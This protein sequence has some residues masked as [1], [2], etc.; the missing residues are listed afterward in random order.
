[1]EDVFC[2]VKSID[3]RKR[4]GVAQSDQLPVCRQHFPNRRNGR[5]ARD[6]GGIRD[7]FPDTAGYP[8][9]GG[10]SNSVSHF[11]EMRQPAAPAAGALQSSLEYL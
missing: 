11:S 6:S 10:A 2:W 5:V 3:P 8:G 7:Y 4:A 9:M 1:M